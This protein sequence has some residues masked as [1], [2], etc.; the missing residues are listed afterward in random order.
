[1]VMLG[2]TM[3]IMGVSDIVLLVSCGGGGAGLS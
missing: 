1:M 3:K 2:K